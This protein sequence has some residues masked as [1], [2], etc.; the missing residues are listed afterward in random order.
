ML[1]FYSYL[2]MIIYQ[3][4]NKKEKWKLWLRSC[5]CLETA[6]RRKKKKILNLSV[7]LYLH[8]RTLYSQQPTDIS[9]WMSH[10][11]LKFKNDNVNYPSYLSIVSP[12]RIACFRER[13]HCNSCCFLNYNPVVPLIFLFPLLVI[14]KE[15][16]HPIFNALNTLE[17]I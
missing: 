2:D 13:H 6:T 17:S 12:L 14:V 9:L 7:D 5:F 1:S 11:H 15:S 16:P 4:L 8:R 10:W 3:S